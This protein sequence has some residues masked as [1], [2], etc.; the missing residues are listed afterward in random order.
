M[1]VTGEMIF[2]CIKTR[3]RERHEFVSDSNIVRYLNH[4]NHKQTQELLTLGDVA[5]WRYDRSNIR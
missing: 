5:E 3:L 4:L 1:R 2:N